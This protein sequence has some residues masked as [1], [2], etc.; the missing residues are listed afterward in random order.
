MD[1]T[2][3]ANQPVSGVLGYDHKHWRNQVSIA[4]IRPDEVLGGGHLLLGDSFRG[5]G[6]MFLTR[7]NDYD[8]FVTMR[9]PTWLVPKLLLGPGTSLWRTNAVSGVIDVTTKSAQSTQGNPLIP[10]KLQT[11]QTMP[12]H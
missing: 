10:R 8:D 11:L 6:G 4:V 5:V 3:L 1:S 12:S 7:G 2:E 9:R